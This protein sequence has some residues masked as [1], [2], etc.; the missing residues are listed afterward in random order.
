[1]TIKEKVEFAS[2]VKQL[3]RLKGEDA[4]SI[5]EAWSYVSGKRWREADEEIQRIF[6]TAWYAVRGDEQVD[7]KKA[8]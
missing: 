2:E 7:S 8:I 3:A 4:V 1:M 6:L 5:W